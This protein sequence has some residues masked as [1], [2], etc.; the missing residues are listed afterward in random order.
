[1]Q[2]ER[3]PNRLCATDRA[4]APHGAGGAG[5]HPP[6]HLQ[7]A[8]FAARDQGP[9]GR[10]SGRAD[11]K[12]VLETAASPILDAGGNMAISP[13][14]WRVAELSAGAI[15]LFDLPPPPYS[16]WCQRRCMPRFPLIE[17]RISP[18][19]LLQTV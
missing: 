18:A 4:S 6:G 9:T 2:N 3:W 12:V 11:G 14:G 10:D 16:L 15:Q 8:A 5:G 13:S 7:F 1:M 19:V 17:R